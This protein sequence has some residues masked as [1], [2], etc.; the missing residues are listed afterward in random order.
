[1]NAIKQN[2]AKMNTATAK[3]LEELEEESARE[4]ACAAAI[5]SASSVTAAVGELLQSIDSA[6][7]VEKECVREEEATVAQLSV[8]GN[9]KVVAQ[10][11]SKKLKVRIPTRFNVASQRA[12][13]QQRPATTCVTVVSCCG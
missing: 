4:A 8:S 2:V 1:M 6:V 3:D 12:S 13:A 5:Q 11:V 9:D 10:D 7:E